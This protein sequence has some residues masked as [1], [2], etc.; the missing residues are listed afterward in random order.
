MECPFCRALTGAHEH[1]CRRCG[2][3]LD[4]S[5]AGNGPSSYAPITTATAPALVEVYEGSPTV[6]EPPQ[7]KP[8]TVVYQ[9]PLFNEMPR[10]M[11]ARQLV[12]PAAPR[13]HRARPPKRAPENQQALDFSEAQGP[14]ELETAVHSVIYCDA[15]AASPGHRFLAAALDTSLVLI[16]MGV[17]MSIFHFAGGEIAPEKS[18]M[19]LIAGITIVLWF[20]YQL[21]FC[22]ADGE[23]PGMNWASLHIINFDGRRPDREQRVY[24]LLTSCLSV[25]AAFLGVIW[26]LVDEEGLTWHDHISKTFPTV[27]RAE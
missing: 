22:L 20:F 21:L 15:L 12:R 19:L 10:V 9:K 23:T 1:R 26:A 13:Q 24:R 27:Q 18:S 14:R 8:A 5:S 3:R 4:G 7:A 11:P 17:F 25:A 6:A 2:R 16:A